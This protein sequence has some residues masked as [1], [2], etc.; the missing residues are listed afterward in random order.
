[1][2]AAFG[3]ERAQFGKHHGVFV[4][5]LD[6]RRNVGRNERAHALDRVVARLD[7]YRYLA[8]DVL[9]RI[10]RNLEEDIFFA[11]D[12]VVQRRFSHPQ[13]FRDLTRRGR[14]VS[15]RPEQF[16]GGV[17]QALRGGSASR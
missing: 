15:L 14:S 8:R 4:L 5:V 7:R 9:E 1:M 11:A 12:V 10:D 16:G 3:R 13:Q 2:R 6:H 17:E